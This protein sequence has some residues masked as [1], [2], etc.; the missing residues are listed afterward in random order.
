[1][2]KIVGIDLRVEKLK[3]YDKGFQAGQQSKQS[4]IDELKREMLNK[5][6]EAYAD[7]QRSMRKM[8]K[9]N[10]DELQ[11][12][13]DVLSKKLNE[14]AHIFLDDLDEILKGDSHES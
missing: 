8:I 14:M 6:N 9:S 2:D 11:K 10:E 3:A 13:I 12:R 1:M 5:T 4:E 7:G